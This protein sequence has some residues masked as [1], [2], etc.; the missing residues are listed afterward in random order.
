VLGEYV[1]STNPLN[2]GSGK[3]GCSV[4]YMFFGQIDVFEWLQF[5]IR[6][7]NWN[8]DTYKTNDELNLYIAGINLKINDNNLLQLNYE[9]EQPQFGG[10][11]PEKHKNTWMAQLKWSW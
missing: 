10:Y 6:Y 11:S 4:G 7:D 5:A 8:P 3:S 9:L 1:V 2:G